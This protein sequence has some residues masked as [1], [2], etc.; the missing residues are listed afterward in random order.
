MVIK[1]L[2]MDGSPNY[3]EAHTSQDGLGAAGLPGVSRV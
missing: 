2:K 3:G 1:V